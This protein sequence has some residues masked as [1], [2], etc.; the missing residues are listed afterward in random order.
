MSRISESQNLSARVSRIRLAESD[1]TTLLHSTRA[2]CV[3]SNRTLAT[4]ASYSALMFDCIA[5]DSQQLEL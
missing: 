3:Q 2:E 1:L 4:L 5:M